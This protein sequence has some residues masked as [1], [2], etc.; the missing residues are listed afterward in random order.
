VKGLIFEEL[1]F[2]VT[3]ALG[4]KIARLPVVFSMRGMEESMGRLDRVHPFFWFLHDSPAFFAGYVAYKSKLLLELRRQALGAKPLRVRLALWKRALWRGLASIRRHGRAGIPP[5]RRFVRNR[6][7]AFPEGADLE[8]VVDLIHGIWL[9]HEVD[10]GILNHTVRR[11]L[12]DP[13]P[14]INVP[15]VR[16]E[17]REPAA[18]DEVHASPSGGRRYVWRREVLAAEPREEIAITPDEMAQVEREL[19]NYR[20]SEAPSTSHP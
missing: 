6:G 18:G 10:F 15:S 2:A 12:G 7:F 8:Q 4:G 9:A 11:L 16:A 14:P 5:L 3:A 19:D 13:L 20:L 1:T 17:W